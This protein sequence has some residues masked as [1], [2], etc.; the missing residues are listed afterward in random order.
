M[1][2]YFSRV[3]LHTRRHT[4]APNRTTSKRIGRLYNG[5]P[6]AWLRLVDRWSPR[7][8]SYIV[9]NAVS[10]A[11]AQKLIYLIFAEAI[12][13]I[14]GSLRIANLTVLVFSIA[15][16]HILHQRRRHTNPMLPPQPAAAAVAAKE[17]TQKADFLH[18]FY[19][20][21]PEVQQILLLRYLCGVSLPEIAQIVGQPEATLTKTIA[22]AARYLH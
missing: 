20:F 17:E 11:E 22:G 6:A 12:Q 2:R 14:V 4:L 7:L 21:A 5:E 15:H 10:E 19:Q 8:Y 9:Y 18:T 3:P 1:H 16:H 13:T